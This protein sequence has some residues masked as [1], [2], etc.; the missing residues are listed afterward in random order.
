MA[1]YITVK[2]D[3]KVYKLFSKLV[4]EEGIDIN[5]AIMEL[6]LE[7]IARD[8]IIKERR[9]AMKKVLEASIT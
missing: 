9:E 1:E 7:A 6:M 2:V 5:Q 3:E 8:Y 4:S